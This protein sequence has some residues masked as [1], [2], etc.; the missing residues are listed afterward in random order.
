MKFLIFSLVFISIQIPIGY[1]ATR[2]VGV[3]GGDYTIQAAEKILT[4]EC[5]ETSDGRT[6]GACDP[7]IYKGKLMCVIPAGNNCTS[8]LST[9]KDGIT[10]IPLE[11][12]SSN[13]PAQAHYTVEHV[14]A[15]TNECGPTPTA[16][17]LAEI[18]KL[19]LNYISSGV[20]VKITIFD[21]DNLAQGHVFASIA[22]DSADSTLGEFLSFASYLKPTHCSCSDEIKEGGDMTPKCELD[23]SWSVYFCEKKN[24]CTACRLHFTKKSS[25]NEIPL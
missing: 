13:M 7:S 8:C 3:L 6:G 18:K 17:Q 21:A 10:I 1:S 11:G 12:N 9:V 14:T 23:D 5:K 15:N 16:D 4:C 22:A 19:P 25:S 20:P 24:G 2:E